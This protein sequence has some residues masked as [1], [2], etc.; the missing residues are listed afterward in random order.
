MA[1]GN[2]PARPETRGAVSALKLSAWGARSASDLGGGALSRWRYADPSLSLTGRAKLKRGRSFF[3][4]FGGCLP[5]WG[6]ARGGLAGL[7]SFT[8]WC[9]GRNLGSLNP[10][11]PILASPPRLPEGDEGEEGEGAEGERGVGRGSADSALCAL[12]GRGVRGMKP[13]S[14]EGE[15]AGCGAG[16]IR[17]RRRRALCRFRAGVM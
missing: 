14:R 10:L 8:P 12:N 6:T 2:S 5:A 7:P 17:G 13:G 16:A 4:I 9:T 15:G 3:R 1:A 11:R